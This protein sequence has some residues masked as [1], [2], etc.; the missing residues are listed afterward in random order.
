MQRSIQSIL[1]IFSALLGG[2]HAKANAATPIK[3]T[4]SITYQEI[5]DLYVNSFGIIEEEPKHSI[6][7]VDT[8]KQKPNLEVVSFSDHEKRQM[9]FEIMADYY[10]ADVSLEHAPYAD[11]LRITLKD[12]DAYYGTGKDTKQSLMS[13]INFTNTMPGEVA[14]AHALAHPLSNAKDIE[15]KQAL[16]KE[17]V[18]NENLFNTVEDLLKRV[19]QAE[20]GFFSYWRDNDPVSNKIFKDLYFK[21]SF[22]KNYNKNSY[23]LESLIRLDNLGTVWHL[24]GD[25]LIWVL[26]DYVM[27][28]GVTAIAEKMDLKVKDAN[29]NLAK[30][31]EP[32]LKNSFK[33]TLNALKSFLDPRE[34]MKAPQYF[35]DGV[36]A[37][38]EFREALG[39]NPF[40]QQE[41][42]LQKKIFYGITGLK[43]GLAVAGIAYKFYSCKK[44]LGLANQTKNAINYLQTRLM[45]V[46]EI[47]DVCKALNALSTKHTVLTDG[48][49]TSD[50][51][52]N[53]FNS[54]AHSS[55]F[56]QLIELLQTD[57][58]KGHA[59]FF[60]L[61]GRVLAA[62][63]LMESEKNNFA[64][65]LSALGELDA[66][67]S[68]AKLYKKMQNERVKMS[69]ATLVKT[70]KPYLKLVDFWNP[71]IDPR[72]VVTNSIELGG[73]ADASKVILTGSNTGGKST[74]LKA[75]MIDLLMIHTFGVS[76]ASEAVVAPM[77]F[78]GSYLRVND[79]TASGESKF[80]A[81]VLRAKMLCDTMDALPQDAFGF[82]VIDELFTGTGS[83]KASAAA[84]KVAQKLACLNNNLYILATHFPHLT[85]LEKENEGV[86][87][88]YKVDVYKDEVG[89]LVRPFKL[90]PGVSTSNVANEI[91]HEEIGSID[92]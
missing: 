37:N 9:L 71:F 63:Q 88:N 33:N 61:S 47:V 43:A 59:S 76:F 31:S 30:I 62:H 53:L 23:A 49:S 80:K 68:I 78:I 70:E 57:T 32:S 8:A 56:G 74:I 69:F 25:L 45:G 6:D 79:D 34:Y 41:I 24:T 38:N 3:K 1:F 40:T 52:L 87:K 64:P 16:I 39:L 28:K 73:G 36:K 72:K 48:V 2:V 14:L 46:A 90:E 83:E 19:K 26:A 91:L 60:S 13:Q 44:A 58:F 92:F 89:N 4:G 20:E 81:E 21:K 7:Q 86:I 85:E 55:E 65:A 50:N 17:L 84:Y 54:H 11:A 15:K 5:G 12:L 22:L 51:L 10:D 82:V 27:S 35:Q 29:G 66:C 18:S 67:L 75:I 77:A 42:E